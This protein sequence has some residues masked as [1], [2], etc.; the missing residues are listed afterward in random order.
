MALGGCSDPVVVVAHGDVLP[1]REA[2]EHGD[3][4]RRAAVQALAVDER[5]GSREA[6][7]A[8]PACRAVEDEF[9]EAGA[10][11]RVGGGG[12]PAVGFGSI[13]ARWMLTHGPASL[14]R[15]GENWTAVGVSAR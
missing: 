12:W 4:G 2:I 7:A 6:R 10:Q 1:A 3:D 5:L 11:Q 13:H 15:S 14:K 9:D 8:E